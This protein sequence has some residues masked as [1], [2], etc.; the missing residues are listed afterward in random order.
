M[1]KESRKK[2]REMQEKM[3]RGEF[4]LT[5]YAV[6]EDFANEKDEFTW[7]LFGEEDDE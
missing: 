4:L 6:L 7:E 3:K 1:D 2:Q 5:H